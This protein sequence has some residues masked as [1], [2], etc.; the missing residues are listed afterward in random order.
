MNGDG[1][2]QSLSIRVSDTSLMEV[3]ILCIV[4]SQLQHRT[5]AV[6]VYLCATFDKNSHL[7]K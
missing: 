1:T 7:E 4:H 6:G 3:S 5:T 2:I